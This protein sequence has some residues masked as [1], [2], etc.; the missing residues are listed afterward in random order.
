MDPGTRGVTPILTASFRLLEVWTP[1]GIHAGRRLLT[2]TMGEYKGE[3]AGRGGK[4]RAG[5][6]D[7]VQDGNLAL[8][9]NVR[10]MT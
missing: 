10:C 6:M 2:S 4:D 9:D 5:N 1:S 8:N 3:E 7:K